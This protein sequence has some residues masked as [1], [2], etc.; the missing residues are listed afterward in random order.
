MG[1]HILLDDPFDSSSTGTV[2]VP[3]SV[4][5]I[6]GTTNSAEVTWASNDAPAGFVFDVRIHQPGMSTLIPWRTAQTELAAG[7]GPGDPLYIGPG[8]YTFQ[9]RLRNAAS[10]AHSGY[11]ALAAITLT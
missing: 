6:P 7:F 3:T 10:G 11:S 5:P 4:Q 8:T 2:K 1:R 9:A